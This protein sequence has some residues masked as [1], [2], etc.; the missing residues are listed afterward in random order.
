MGARH[1]VDFFHLGCESEQMNRQDRL[2]AACNGCFEARWIEVVGFAI[3]IHEDRPGL[4]P[5]NA[6]GGGDEGKGRGG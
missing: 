6:S 4:Q 3:N 5:R 2:G 1:F